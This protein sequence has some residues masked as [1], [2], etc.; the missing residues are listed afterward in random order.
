MLGNICLALATISITAAA[1]PPAACEIPANASGIQCDMDLGRR[2][3]AV[4]PAACAAACCAEPECAAWQYGNASCGASDGCGCWLGHINVGGQPTGCH[5]AA[6]WIGGSR[7]PPDNSPPPPPPPAP[8][9]VPPASAAV[10]SAVP[11]PS[12]FS[13]K[14]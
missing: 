9:G 1:V 11:P 2:A 8:S 6:A 12:N 10:R 13:T 3:A 5:A 14:C 7:V 4:T